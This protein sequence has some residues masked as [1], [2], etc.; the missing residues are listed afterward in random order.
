M[1]DFDYENE[2]DLKLRYISTYTLDKLTQMVG[3][4]EWLIDFEESKIPPMLA[5]PY[6]HVRISLIR[7]ELKQSNNI[8]IESIYCFL[9]NDYFKKRF[10]IKKIKPYSLEKILDYNF[11][12]SNDNSIIT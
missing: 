3:L 11:Y 2:E 5:H 8:I 4:I 10:N 6:D 9:M 12:P 7:K 1:K